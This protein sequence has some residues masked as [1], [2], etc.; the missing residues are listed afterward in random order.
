MI[1]QHGCTIFSNFLSRLRE[2]SPSSRRVTSGVPE[3]FLTHLRKAM[4]KVRAEDPLRTSDRKIPK[5]RCLTL[6]NSLTSPT[7]E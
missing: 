2:T 1:F 5:A 4:Y 3:P 6:P 7:D